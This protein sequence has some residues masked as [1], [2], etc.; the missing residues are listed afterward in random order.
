MR[1]IGSS[2]I[3]LIRRPVAWT[4][5]PLSQPPPCKAQTSDLDPGG[6][7]GEIEW[8]ENL[9]DGFEATLDLRIQEERPAPTYEGD[10]VAG[11]VVR[12]A[13]EAQPRRSLKKHVHRLFADA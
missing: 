10:V 3:A 11:R 12:Q 8:R 9:T 1:G 7:L 5:W 6:G 13:V 2:S 4:I